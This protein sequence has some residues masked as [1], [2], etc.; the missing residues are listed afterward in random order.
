MVSTKERGNWV[1]V[2]LLHTPV[3][4]WLDQRAE[5]AELLGRERAQVV[6]VAELGLVQ[7]GVEDD[8]V[9]EAAELRARAG[10][11]EEA[12]DVLALRDVRAR[13]RE[14]HE[15]LWHCTHALIGSGFGGVQKMYFKK[16]DGFE[17]TSFVHLSIS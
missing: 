9:R 6:C 10:D 2:G 14:E 13:L 11:V 5:G 12:H 3:T 17:K 7:V 16:K 15:L 8:D 4:D 1:W